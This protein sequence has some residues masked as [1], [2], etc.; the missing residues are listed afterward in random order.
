MTDGITNENARMGY[1]WVF[2]GD[3]RVFLGVLGC[4]LEFAGV[5]CFRVFLGAL[6]CFLCVSGCFVGVL[7]FSGCFWGYIW[8]LLGV[9]GL[10]CFLEFSIVF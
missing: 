6:G 10:I 3:F 2:L 8:V 1:I 5:R 7:G 9:H 4:F